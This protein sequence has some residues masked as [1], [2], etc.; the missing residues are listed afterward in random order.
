MRRV[1]RKE[2]TTC[3]APAERETP[4]T[5]GPAPSRAEIDRKARER[6][7][8]QLTT[9]PEPRGSAAKCP[10]PKLASEDPSAK[11]I[12]AVLAPSRR[13]FSFMQ[14]T[15]EIGRLRG[16]AS[17]EKNPVVRKAIQAREREL[18]AEWSRRAPSM[19][20]PAPK[21]GFDPARASDH[22]LLCARAWRDVTGTLPRDVLA[23]GRTDEYLRALD[24]QS[25]LRDSKTVR[26]FTADLEKRDPERLRRLVTQELRRTGDD[27]DH[28]HIPLGVLRERFICAK[29][30]ALPSNE[31]ARA[32]HMGADGFV[33][34]P[35]QVSDYELRERL[36]LVK[37]DS[38]VGT[39]ATGVAA[40]NGA[41][42]DRL[43]AVKQGAD[44]MMSGFDAFAPQ[45]RVTRGETRTDR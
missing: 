24:E 43:R 26:A 17:E 25:S 38:V 20:Y 22:D 39:L 37:T 34:T 1:S 10:W 3:H 13:A 18:V 36:K 11:E 16:K 9:G 29:T 19:G 27:R 12:E 23:S 32:K 30:G 28:D 33:G 14:L 31:P 21:A 15:D 41:D 40:H 6:L 4:R 7:D 2:E 8:A 35:E 44:G 45:N 42:V 5:S